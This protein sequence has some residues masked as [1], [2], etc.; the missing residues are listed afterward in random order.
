MTELDA[1]VTIY[2]V[3]AITLWASYTV[4]MFYRIYRDRL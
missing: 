1:F 2:T 4:R 3:T